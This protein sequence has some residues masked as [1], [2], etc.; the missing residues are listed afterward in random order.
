MYGHLLSKVQSPSM[1]IREEVKKVERLTW[2]GSSLG[3]F[4]R[5]RKSD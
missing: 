3:F 2:K 4:K 1:R 5:E